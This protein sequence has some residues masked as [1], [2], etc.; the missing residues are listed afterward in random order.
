MGIE[1]EGDK[2]EELLRLSRE[3]N[4]MLRGMRRS[5]LMGA[6]F[7]TVMWIALILVPLWFY[8]QYVAP[9]MQSMM[10]TYEQIQGTNA[11]AQA[12]FGQFSDSMERLQ[13]FFGREE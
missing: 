6:I 3:N 9:V 11:A 5:S 2:M 12:Q 13:S 4:R 1:Y 10:A 8:V 7:K